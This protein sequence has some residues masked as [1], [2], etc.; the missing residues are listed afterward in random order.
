MKLRAFL[1]ALATLTLAACDGA[2]EGNMPSVEQQ[3]DRSAPVTTP[4]GVAVVATAE[5]GAARNRWKAQ[6]ELTRTVAGNLT[7]SLEGGR[8]GALILAFAN[9]I[10]MRL[11]RIAD[12]VGADRTGSGNVT[13]SSTLGADPNAAVFVYRVADETIARS[14][15][16]GG[17]CQGARTSHVA[18]SEFVNRQGDWVFTLAA[19]R[20]NAAPG[21]Q[22]GADPQFCA[23][24]GYGVI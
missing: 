6:T 21:P 23:A 16:S 2:G 7:A 20:G 10:T 13:F 3:Q 4:E 9:G 1:V 5:P 19:Y 8:G 14:A 17:L 22:S 24:Y 18:L 15:A 11:E 12:Q